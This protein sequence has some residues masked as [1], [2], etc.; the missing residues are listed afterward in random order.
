MSAESSSSRG[1]RTESSQVEGRN[2]TEGL[3]RR[4]QIAPRIAEC[5]QMALSGEQLTPEQRLKVNEIM[6]YRVADIRTMLRQQGLSVTGLKVD[7]AR[8]LAVLGEFKR[9]W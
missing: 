1:Y 9:Q 4:G 2:P 7:L 8:R 3:T 5:Q 6:G